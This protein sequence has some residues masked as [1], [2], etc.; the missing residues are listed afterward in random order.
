MCKINLYLVY[1]GNCCP[2][3]I[4]K[5]PS[6]KKDFIFNNIDKK[7]KN[8]NVYSPDNFILYGTLKTDYFSPLCTKRPYYAQKTCKNCNTIFYSYREREFCSNDCSFSNSFK[9]SYNGYN[10]N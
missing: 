5:K 7:T 6:Q 10:S 2:F 4:I 3:K 9:L 1:M 8:S